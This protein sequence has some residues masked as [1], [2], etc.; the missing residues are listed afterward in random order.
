MSNSDNSDDKLDALYKLTQQPATVLSEDSSAEDMSPPDIDA[1]ILA[2]ARE[3][4]TGELATPSGEMEGTGE[5]AGKSSISSWQHRF[6]WA[7]AAT[8]LLTSVLFVSLVDNEP[9]LGALS[10]ERAM[11]AN[12]APVVGQ[13]RIEQPRAK[14]SRIEPSRIE[15][16]RVEPSRVGVDTGAAMKSIRTTNDVQAAA[17]ELELESISSAADISKSTLKGRPAPAAPADLAEFSKQPRDSQSLQEKPSAA[18]EEIVVTGRSVVQDTDN[19]RTI[20]VPNYCLDYPGLLISQVCKNPAA[21]SASPTLQANRQSECA[22]ETLT[23]SAGSEAP[24]PHDSS[25]LDRFVLQNENTANEPTEE[26]VCQSGK[27]VRQSLARGR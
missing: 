17:P 24:T 7:T 23:L 27:L 8:V 21:L 25:T 22:G 10:S 13:S 14:P 4:I 11:Q 3:A 19:A 5:S 20:S 18:I 9:K 2:A 12:D 1:T 16:S 15:P 26:I 6:G